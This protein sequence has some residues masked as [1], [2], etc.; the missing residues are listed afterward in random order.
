MGYTWRMPW[1]ETCVKNERTIMI[2][3]Y[4]GGDFSIAEVA[5]RRGVSRKTVYKW[6]ERY[7]RG[8]GPGLKDASRAAPPSSQC[9]FPAGGGGD[10]GMESQT[11]FVGRAQDSQQADRLGGLSGGKYGVRCNVLRRH[12]LTRQVR[13]RSH[14]PPSHGGPMP[15]VAGAQ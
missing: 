5:R 3:E 2:S 14:H 9:H 6:I 15:G 13:R 12:G 11:A 10:F 8:T 1:K 7:E 4:I